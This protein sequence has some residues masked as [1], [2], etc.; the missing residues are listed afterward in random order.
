FQHRKLSGR[1]EREK[2]VLPL[3]TRD[4]IDG[5]SVERN[6]KFLQRPAHPDRARRRELVEFHGVLEQ[7]KGHRPRPQT[8]RRRS[9]FDT[10][11]F[12]PV[13]SCGRENRRP[14]SAHPRETPPSRRLDEFR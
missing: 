6:A 8:C 14:L 4:Q 10:L 11:S 7:K 5:N 3:L 9:P 13:L 12:S 2:R 1:V